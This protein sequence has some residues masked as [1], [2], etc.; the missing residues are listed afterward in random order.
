MADG[1]LIYRSFVEA[2]EELDE[3]DQLAAYK[4]LL[5]YGLDGVEPQSKGA[6]KAILLMA[7]P[8]MD[9]NARKAENGRKGGEA[10]R[11]K[12]EASS[13]QAEANVKQ[14]EANEEQTEANSEK[15]EANKTYNIKDK[16]QEI[17][18]I[19]NRRFTPPSVDEVRAY[20]FEKGYTF[21]PEAF[22]AFYQS[23][24]WKVGNTPMK[25]WKACCV[26]WSKRKEAPRTQGKTK[27]SNF[28]QHDYDFDD[29]ERK[30]LAA[31]IGG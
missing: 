26:T 15:A 20:C 16:T 28:E 11:G 31:Q 17:K 1:V 27:F 7:K 29:I 5:A 19:K 23:K 4:A 9:K 24:G 12:S 14:I 30:L 3:K 2:I 18:D 13:K 8:I 21:D 25:D 10:N 22:V 6:A